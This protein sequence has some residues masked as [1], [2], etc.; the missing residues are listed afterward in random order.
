MKILGLVNVDLEMDSMLI[1][2]W[3]KKKR[4]GLWYFEDYLEGILDILA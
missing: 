4:C 3:V 2:Q 1:V